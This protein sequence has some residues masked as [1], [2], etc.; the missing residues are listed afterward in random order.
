M[1]DE[2][3][4]SEREGSMTGIERPA[5]AAKACLRRLRPPES[6]L[7]KQIVPPPGALAT[8]AGGNAGAVETRK[9]LRL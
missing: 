7:G 9:T 3:V 2:S 4:R 5:V 1:G 8:V 6:R